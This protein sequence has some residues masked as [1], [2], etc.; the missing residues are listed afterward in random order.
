MFCRDNDGKAK[1]SI[2]RSSKFIRDKLRDSK[3]WAKRNATSTTQQQD[4]NGMFHAK[5]TEETTTVDSS[6]ESRL[7]RLFSIRK[8]T[9]TNASPTSPNA[10]AAMPRVSEEEEQMLGGGTRPTSARQEQPPCLAAAPAGLGPEELKRRHIV[11]SLVQSENNYVASLQRLVND[12]KKQLEDANP[13]IISGNKVQ[14]LFHRVN[15]ILHHHTLFRIALSEAIRNWDRDEAIGDVF[16]A[17]F[18]KALVL[19][20]Y[21]EFINNFTSAMELARQ[22]SKRKSAFADFLKLKQIDAKDRVSFFGL[23][24]KPVQRFPQ[25]I[26]LLQDLLKETPPGHGDRMALQLALTTLESLAEMLNER[27][28]EAEQFAAF[29]E[30]MRS[31]S[32]SKFSSGHRALLLSHD[33]FTSLAQAANAGPNSGPSSLGSLSGS[34]TLPSAPNG[35]LHCSQGGPPLRF[36]LREDNVTLLE[37]NSNGMIS[38]SKNRRLL[39]LNDLLVCVS[40]NGRSQSDLEHAKGTERLTL[41]WAVPV[42]DVELIDGNSGGTLARLLFSGA[43]GSSE[44][45]GGARKRTSLTRTLTPSALLTNSDTSPNGGGGASGLQGVAEDLA[46]DMNDLMHDFDVV[47]RISS[48]IGTL[49][50]QYEV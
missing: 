38:R 5:S 41:K 1:S 31:I 39:L 23:M 14:I 47:A 10:A 22:E 8:S 36:L 46:Q 26:L 43:S 11:N 21:S 15:E 32:S 12:Y 34:S 25:F 20:I 27:K 19:E 45:S 16:V 44:A 9:S 49:K 18:S 30:K 4:D 42:G 29:K 40:V 37:F 3:N 2:I 28:R 6:N 7:A 35:S 13:P 48:L 50:G 33:E 24:V 17:T